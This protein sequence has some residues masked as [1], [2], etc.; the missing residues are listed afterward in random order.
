MCWACACARVTTP[1]SAAE[2]LTRQ[3]QPPIRCFA[4][5]RFEPVMLVFAGILLLSSFKLLL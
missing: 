2:P 5:E 1:A 4:V 3:R